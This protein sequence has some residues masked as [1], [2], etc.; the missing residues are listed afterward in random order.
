VNYDDSVL[1]T[2]NV[3]QGQ[4]A[5]Y[6]GA[7]PTRPATSEFTYVFTGWD[8]T[9]TNITSAFTTKAQFSSTTNTYTVT[10]QNHDGTVLET[11]N[12][13]PYGST[14][15]FNSSN[16]TKTSTDDY[17][18]GFTGW[19]PAIASVT[20]N[21]TYVA[22]FTENLNYI[23]IT[24]AQELN[25]IRNN[26]SGN[27]RLMN[28]ID[29]ESVEWT[30]I[31]TNIAPF[32]G[33]LDGKE[34]IISNLTI[35]QT[36]EYVGL[37]SNNSGTIKNLKL[38]NVQIN[39][40]GSISSFIYVG[41]LVANNTGIIANIETLSGSLFA[42]ARG[43]N[44]GYVGGLVGFHNRNTTL[45][46]LTN[47]LNVSGENTTS[48]G[49]VIGYT[50][51][52]ITIT[53]SMN[54][55]SVSGTR[56]VGGLIGY[57]SSGTT[58][59]ITNSMNSGSVSGGNYVGGLIGYGSSGTTTTITN[60]MNSGSVSGGFSVGGLV[61]SVYLSSTTITNSMN[62]GSVSGGSFVGG[63][64]GSG[65]STTTITNSMNSGSV[66][67]TSSRIG[68]LIGS[69]SSTTTIT[70]SMN[71]GSVSGSQ[72]IGGLIGSGSS[73]TTITNSMNSG[74]VSGSYHV[75]GLVGHGWN[76]PTITN[77]MNSGSVSGTFNVGGLI[78]Y[79]EN[80]LFVYY[81][82][83][84]GNVV[85]TNATTAVGGI[86]GRIP[87]TNDVEE[88]YHFGSITSNGVEVAGTNF[89]TKVTDISTFNL[90]FFTTTLGWDAE[91]W[92]FTGLDIAN[93]VYPTLKNMPVVEE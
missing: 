88:A 68:G 92:D 85:A 63:L 82:I 44:I 17:N 74:S 89:G 91:V 6:V 21:I 67:G 11:D 27:Y 62:S 84:L 43:G 8:R 46:K 33:T 83:N 54:S 18:Y 66:S 40:Q 3:I 26:L 16:P 70:N 59:T 81:S 22:Q 29:L 71:S 20:E 61:G 55:G 47:N 77:S 72:Q 79:A 4:T 76:T 93:G 32:S 41:A 34:F 14:P 42:R 57:V 50:A 45:D 75:G 23:P 90:A 7:T 52:R 37:F 2:T 19:L 25:N 9:L 5:V 87:S 51:S 78:G 49:G 30:P 1:Y 36:Q 38:E 24:N 15:T 10:W 73:G 65:S 86:A 35:T 31:G 56:E 12:N 48:M 60:S 80:Q 58:T 28:D 69:G 13:V 39:V 64:I 53:N